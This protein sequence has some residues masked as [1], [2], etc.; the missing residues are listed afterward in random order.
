M[1]E[2]VHEPRD[3]SEA[4]RCGVI[5]VG[6]LF[7]CPV[8][9]LVTGMNAIDGLLEGRFEANLNEVARKTH[10]WAASLDILISLLIKFS[11]ELLGIPG[12]E[13]EFIILVLDLLSKERVVLA[14]DYLPPHSEVTDIWVPLKSLQVLCTG[15]VVENWRG[16]SLFCE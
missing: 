11:I 14:F 10:C 5:R 16:E 2:D 12:S 4:G 15:I 8:A 9:S 3:P 13:S 1:P 6:Q 7:E